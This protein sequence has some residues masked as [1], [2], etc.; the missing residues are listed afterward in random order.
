MKKDR[1]YTDDE[2]RAII[3]RALKQQPASGVSHEELL[4]IGA[5]VGLSPAALESAAREVVDARLT[6]TATERVVARKRRGVLA[7]AFVYFTVNGVL[8]TINLLTTPG[9]WWVLFP[10]LAWGIGMILHAGFGLFSR[11]SDYSLVQEKR[12]MLKAANAGVARLAE[13]RAGV[14]VAGPVDQIEDPSLDQ[15]PE[16]ARSQRGTADQ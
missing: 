6:K 5:G 3:E 10:V 12:R 15:D 7:H 9:Q 14:R 4:S 1:S 8:F 11:V 16:S 2:V 13:R